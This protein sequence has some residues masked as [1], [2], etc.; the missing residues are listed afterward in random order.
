MTTPAISDP[1]IIAGMIRE[2][3]GQLIEGDTLQF[4]LP[5]GQERHSAAQPQRE[6]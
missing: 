4:D 6:P 2:L 5:L 3:G 1:Q